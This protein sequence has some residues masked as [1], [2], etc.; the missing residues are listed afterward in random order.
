M[1]HAIIV[2]TENFACRQRVVNAEDD[3]PAAGHRRATLF[4]GGLATE[5]GPM[6]SSNFSSSKM[7]GTSLIAALHPSFPG[8]GFLFSKQ[9][10]SDYGRRHLAAHQISSAVRIVHRKFDLAGYSSTEVT[11]FIFRAA[12]PAP[13]MLQ[14][15]KSMFN[16]KITII[17]IC[18]NRDGSE[19]LSSSMNDEFCHRSGVGHRRG[20]LRERTDK[21]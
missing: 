14:L 2:D 4:F 18:T 3:A 5:A 19:T 9:G 10:L 13:T 12:D 11:M 20:I 16:S 1:F 8:L 15:N 21:S 17:Y 7:P 6:R